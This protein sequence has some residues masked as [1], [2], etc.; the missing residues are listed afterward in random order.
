[1]NRAAYEELNRARLTH[2]LA[3]LNDTYLTNKTEQLTIA[4]ELTVEHIMPQSWMEKWLLPD[5]A[6]GMAWPELLEAA[7]DEPRAVATTARD[8]AIH[9]FGN[10]TLLTQALNSSV[11]NEQWAAKK[12]ALCASSLLPINL[13]LHRYSSWDEATI[14]QRGQELLGRAVEIWP[15]P[16]ASKA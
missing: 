5:G 15:G 8:R 14:T 3:K 9:T 10:L 13:Q 12:P 6:R 1:M 16:P 2:V 7:L 11:S 4:S